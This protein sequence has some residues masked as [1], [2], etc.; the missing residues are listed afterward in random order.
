VRRIAHAVAGLLIAASA[1]AADPP[2]AGRYDAQLC[3]TLGAAAPS[4]G[5]ADAQVQRGNRVRVRISDIEYRLQL[6]SSQLDVVMMH[7]AMQ[8]DGFVANYAWTPGPALEFV[9][10]DKHTRYELRLTP[11]AR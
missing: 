4:C 5:P 7:G 10:A 9:D 1:A 2:A 8:I 6:H 11:P 3:V